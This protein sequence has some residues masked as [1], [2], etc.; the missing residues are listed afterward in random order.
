MG[1]VVNQAFVR[2]SFAS[3]GRDRSDQCLHLIRDS[4]GRMRRDIAATL[5]AIALALVVS[6]PAGA[7]PVAINERRLALFA[8]Y[9]DALRIQAGIPGLSAAV[10]ASGRVVWEAGYGFADLEAR[11]AATPAT[12]YRI[13]SLTKTFTSTL[14]GECVEARTL[15][16]DARMATYTTSVPDPSASVRHVLSM[17]SDAPAGARFRYDGDRFAT[18]TPVVDACTGRPYRVA[19]ASRILD[20]LAMTDSVPGQDLEAPPVDV[21]ALFDAATRDRYR[22][23]LERLA[24]PYRTVRGHTSLGDYP[25]RGINAAAG[26]V[27]TVRDL[28]RYDAA[29]DSGILLHAD[30]QQLAWMPFRLT[31]GHTAPYGLG[32]FSQSSQAGPAIWH[33]GLWPTY[34][35][36]LLKLPERGVTLILLANSDGLSARFPLS[37]GDVS[38]SPFARAFIAAVR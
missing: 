24:K 12:P 36:L 11:V 5:T 8:G 2:R 16:L 37:G 29:L 15:D 30:T 3:L 31:D 19:V 18:L 17:T 21:A 6:L 22:R 35:S 20:R 25:P 28:A 7:Q 13:A 26:I 32:W 23:V 33:F 1:V 27:S 34:S 9:L 10:V 14:L 38:V 4:I